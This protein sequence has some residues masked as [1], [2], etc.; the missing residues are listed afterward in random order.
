MLDNARKYAEEVN[1]KLMDTWY[2]DKYKYYSY[3]WHSQVEMPDG[4]WNTMCFVSVDKDI[5]ENIF[6][7]VVLPNAGSYC[8]SMEII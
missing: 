3:N 8:C 1:N 6:K 4:D 5:D 7:Y 2:D